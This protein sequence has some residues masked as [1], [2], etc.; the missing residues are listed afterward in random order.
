M[1][2]VVNN[3]FFM[4][5]KYIDCNISQKIITFIQNLFPIK[6]TEIRLVVTNAL[7][8]FCITFNYTVFRN[9]KD[10]LINT[11]ASSGPEVTCFIKS[12]LVLPI[13][14]LCFIC[15]T[16][17]SNIFSRQKI[18]YICNTFFL[19]FFFL[20][21]F[22]L[23]P[24]KE[25]I[26]PSVETINKLQTSYPSLQWIFPIYGIWSYS[27]FYIF[28]ELWG[29]IMMSLLFWEY[30]NEVTTTEEA[31]RFYPFFILLANVG[32]MVAG[33]FVSNLLTNQDPGFD[34]E[35]NW[36][37]SLK[38]IITITTGIG[39]LAMLLYKYSNILTTNKAIDNHSISDKT[40]DNK[41]QLNF[42]QSVKCICS[43]T[44]LGLIA[45]L[46]ISYGAAI[47][48]IELTWKKQLAMYFTDPSQYCAFM[49]K[50]SFYTGLATI[51]TILFTKKM[52][53]YSK[54]II[55]AIF[56]P[57]MLAATGFIFYCSLFYKNSLLSSGVAVSASLSLTII[58]VGA[59]QNILSKSSKYAL[60]DPAKE[61]TYI[62]LNKE[63]K[64]KG[65]AAVDV[66]G[67]RLG[68]ASGGYIQQLL[69]I[70]SGGS[71][72]SLTPILFVLVFIIITFWIISTFKLNKK[73]L[74]ILNTNNIVNSNTDKDPIIQPTKSSQ[75]QNKDINSSL[76]GI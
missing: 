37:F 52:F 53:R 4:K 65:K 51:I 6:K 44:Y 30:A 45:I 61:I 2:T 64:M 67:E 62:P 23:Y 12:W 10:T 38:Y 72:L 24:N 68:K 47:N 22:Y 56:T 58:M 57:V 42:I 70:I 73:Y 29:S 43:S 19:I 40:R 34:L 39:I 18:F 60:F 9:L 25:A 20:F 5:T 14:I 74:E 50:F 26:H 31:K 3:F 54:W 33:S 76:Q 75:Y 71:I 35:Y 28:A 1:L 55:A 13:S 27:L 36:Y 46:V 41:L 32:L 17:L 48:L 16:K 63:L 59:I 15:I 49:S 7:L 69:L 21:C 8:L 11:A 66:V